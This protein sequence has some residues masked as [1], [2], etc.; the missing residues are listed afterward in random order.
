MHDFDFLDQSVEVNC[1][2]PG[3]SVYCKLLILC[4]DSMIIILESRCMHVRHQCSVCCNTSQICP[5]LNC[6]QPLVDFLGQSVEVS[7]TLPG[8]QILRLYNIDAYT[9]WLKGCMYLA[10]VIC[11]FNTSSKM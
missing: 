3:T 9:L 1:I 6:Y 5:P 2:H 10:I 7:C 8:I 4:N 11:S